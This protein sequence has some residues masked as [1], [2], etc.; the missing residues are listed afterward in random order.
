MSTENAIQYGQVTASY[1][2]DDGSGVNGDTGAPASGEPMQE[3]LA[4]SPSW[5]LG[6]EGYV[7]Y[8][9]KKAD[10]F[11]GD[12]GPGDPADGCNVL[13]DLDGK[14]FA[15]LTGEDWNES[16]YTVSGGEGHIDVEYV[17]TKWGDGNGTE[18]APRPMGSGE[19]CTD[20]VSPVPDELSGDDK[21]DKK[22]EK[23]ESGDAKESKDAKD[24]QEQGAAATGGDGDGGPA[25]HTGTQS[26]TAANDMSAVNFAATDA[27]LAA[28]ALAMALIPALVVALLVARR[29]LVLAWVGHDRAA[30]W[31][32]KAAALRDRGAQMGAATASRVRAAAADAVAAV[33]ERFGRGE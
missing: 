18:G 9:G 26:S 31:G 1:F 32:G 14:T 33:R 20:A 12:R 15:K 11:I 16:G 7:K 6:T 25:G 24:G 23:K 30:A 21:Q 22:D 17:I 29:D 5:P 10:F 13:L 27:P 4:A 28:G 8:N 3:G 2:W 19:E